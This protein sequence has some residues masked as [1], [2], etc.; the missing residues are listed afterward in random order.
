MGGVGVGGAYT[1]ASRL[2]LHSYRQRRHSCLGCFVEGM[3][4]RT[5]TIVNEIGQGGSRIRKRGFAQY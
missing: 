5:C 2:I 3:E 4:Q 1:V